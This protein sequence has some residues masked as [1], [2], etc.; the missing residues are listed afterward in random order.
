MI[1]ARHTWEPDSFSL[2]QGGM[3]VRNGPAMRG[4]ENICM[5]SGC[6]KCPNPMSSDSYRAK[7]LRFMAIKVWYPSR[8]KYVH[9]HMPILP[10]PSLMRISC[11]ISNSS[12]RRG[13]SRDAFV[14]SVPP[15]S[16]NEWPAGWGR[17]GKVTR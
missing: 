4:C 5:L 8:I 11:R 2:A 16:E 7:W 10:S 6:F 15:V 17:G 12:K 14:Q 3:I 1:V 13:M 9:S